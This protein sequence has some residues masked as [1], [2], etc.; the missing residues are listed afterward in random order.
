MQINGVR[1]CG[2]GRYLEDAKARF[3]EKMLAGLDGAQTAPTRSACPAAPPRSAVSVADYAAHY[4][5]TFKKPNISEKYYYNLCGIVKRHISRFFA[6]K[7]MRDITATDCQ[8]FLNELMSE[9]KSRTAE[10][11]KSLLSWI[12]SAAVADRLLAADVMAHVQILPHRRTI[13]KAIPREYIRAFFEKEPQTPAEL[14]LWLLAYTG[15]RPCELYAL[16][17]DEKGFVTIQTAK[18]K[19]WEEAE[20]RRVP[21]HSALAPY[22]ER[23]RAAVPVSLFLLERAFKRHFPR[24][25]RLYDLRH[26]FTT[27]TQEAHCY[28]SWVDYVTGHKA[29]GNTTDRVYTHWEDDFQLAEIE[30]LKY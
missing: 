11:A 26:T 6:G 14:C 24:D 2:T 23:I 13:G 22:L 18:R 16:T 28:K 20:T 5:D 12:C 10:D 25:F 4:L 8:R 29:G 27:A 15:M 30:K 21:L 1:F 7:Y 19:K 9:G 3:I 17:F